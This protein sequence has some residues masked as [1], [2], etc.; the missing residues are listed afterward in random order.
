MTTILSA[1]ITLTL[2]YSF[3]GWPAQ[4]QMQIEDR[5]GTG[6]VPRVAV[7]IE[8]SSHRFTHDENEAF[9]EINGKKQDDPEVIEALRYKQ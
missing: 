9:K 4:E 6:T 7:V 2:L 8:S 3:W 5:N 1:A